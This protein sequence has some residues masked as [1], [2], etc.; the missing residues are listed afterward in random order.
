MTVVDEDRRNPS[1]MVEGGGEAADVPAI[2]HRDQREHR[3]LSV[4][5]GV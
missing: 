4:L 2:A 1:L 3:D 5:G